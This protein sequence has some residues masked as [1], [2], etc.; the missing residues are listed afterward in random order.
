MT[1]RYDPKSLSYL[2]FAAAKRLSSTG[3]THRARSS[4]AVSSRSSGARQR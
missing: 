1:L 4:S 2:S 3:A